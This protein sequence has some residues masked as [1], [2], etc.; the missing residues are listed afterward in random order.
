MSLCLIRKRMVP[1]TSV[2]FRAKIQGWPV[3]SP[4]RGQ[5]MTLP[6]LSSNETNVCTVRFGSKTGP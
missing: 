3:A 1:L 6:P 5:V 2:G 4:G